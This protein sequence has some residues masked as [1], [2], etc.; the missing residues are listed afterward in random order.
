MRGASVLMERHRL[1]EIRRLA[2]DVARLVRLLSA[3]HRGLGGAAR[4]AFRR[5]RANLVEEVRSP[6]VG[7]EPEDAETHPNERV[8]RRRQGF[9]IERVEIAA[10]LRRT[11]H[12]RVVV[13]LT[14]GGLYAHELFDRIGVLERGR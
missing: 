3:P 4:S 14:G 1:F 10:M 11:K 6:R 9:L 5:L 7:G 13:L 12:G 2:A 8:G